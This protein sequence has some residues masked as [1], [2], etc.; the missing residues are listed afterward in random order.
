MSVLALKGERVSAPGRTCAC[1]T[2]CHE[3]RWYKLYSFL[4]P[5]FPKSTIESQ[6]ARRF[7]LFSVLSGLLWKTG[8]RWKFIGMK[9]IGRFP[10]NQY[11]RRI[12]VSRSGQME[13]LNCEAVT[14]KA[15]QSFSWQHS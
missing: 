2:S 4:P 8:L 7:K 11:P 3:A 14:T 12:E 10:Q 5:L 6:Y 13:E 1:R 9:F 15:C